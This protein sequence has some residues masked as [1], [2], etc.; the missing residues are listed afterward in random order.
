M[1]YFRKLLPTIIELKFLLFYLKSIASINSH[2]PSF[3][4]VLKIS[5]L[6]NEQL[7]KNEE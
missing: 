1:H 5:V 3:H 4:C 7:L 2:V 6:Y